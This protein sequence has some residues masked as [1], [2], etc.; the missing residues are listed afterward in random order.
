MFFMDQFL[1]GIK[2]QFDDDFADRLNYYYTPWVIIVM[3]LTIRYRNLP[4]LPPTAFHSTPNNTAR[5]PF[6]LGSEIDGL[7][8]CSLLSRCATQAPSSAYGTC[9]EWRT[10]S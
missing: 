9:V 3:A 8:E 2:P 6:M 5:M 7:N 10:Q 1:A 4:A